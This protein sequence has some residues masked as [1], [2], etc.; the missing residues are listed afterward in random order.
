MKKFISLLHL[1]PKLDIQSIPICGN[2]ETETIVLTKSI[3]YL[4][5]NILFV[6]MCPSSGWFQCSNDFVSLNLCK[7]YKW[8]DHLHV[9]SI[10]HYL[11]IDFFKSINVKYNCRNIF[12]KQCITKFRVTHPLFAV[13]VIQTFKEIPQLY[14]LYYVPFPGPKKICEFSS[15]FKNVLFCFQ[16]CWR[17]CIQPVDGCRLYVR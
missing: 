5:E 3:A 13:Y 7:C 9:K 17:N 11:Q 4:Q 12:P 16:V 6:V 8:R 15:N 14:I 1:L 10:L 2:F